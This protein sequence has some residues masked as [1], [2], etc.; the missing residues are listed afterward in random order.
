MHSQDK[1]VLYVDKNGKVKIT[2]P[3]P[4]SAGNEYSFVIKKNMNTRLCLIGIHFETDKTFILPSAIPGIKKIGTIYKE[5][6]PKEVLIVGHTDT[7][8]RD[9]YNQIL[10]TQRANSVHAYLMDNVDEWLKNYSDSIP[11]SKRWGKHEDTLMLYALNG[12]STHKDEKMI[13]EEFQKDRN[14]KVDGIIG[15]E[16]RK[17]L[18]KEYMSIDGTS[19]P[20]FIKVETHGCGE[21]HPYVDSGNNKN[22]KL[23]RRVELFFFQE[24]IEPPVPGECSSP[25]GCEEYKQ[26][27]QN[28]GQTISADDGNKDECIVE[29]KVIYSRK[30]ILARL[31]SASGTELPQIQSVTIGGSTTTNTWRSSSGAIYFIPPEM[32]KDIIVNAIQINSSNVEC[33]LKEP[34]TFSRHSEE[35]AFSIKEQLKILREALS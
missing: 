24:K 6:N 11:E 1:T 12:T 7:E 29:P 35:A 14:L 5:Q 26:W 13:I 8:G 2:D 16:T 27:L 23:N 28:V 9:A 22:E 25:E 17:Q 15:P 31:K 4:L 30:T 32:D 20:S 21:Y 18:I 34:L 10:S 33:S 19:L 3:I